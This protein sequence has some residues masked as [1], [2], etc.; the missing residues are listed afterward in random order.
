MD[1][2]A[3]AAVSSRSRLAP[4]A[5]ENDRLD[6]RSSGTLR[7]NDS[8]LQLETAGVPL[9]AQLS[10]PSSRNSSVSSSATVT[11]TQRIASSLEQLS[12]LQ[13]IEPH[14]VPLPD[15]AELSIPQSHAS[16]RNSTAGVGSGYAFNNSLEQ[17]HH[18]H[19]G[20]PSEMPLPASNSS[21]SVNM[22]GYSILASRN[23]AFH[24]PGIVKRDYW[25]KIGPLTHFMP[26]LK[27]VCPPKGRH[28]HAGKITCVDYFSHGDSRVGITIDM[29]NVRSCSG[30][31]PAIRQ[32]KDLRTVKDT[33]VRSRIIL[34]E[35]LCSESIELL[36]T[37]FELDPEI[38]AEHLNRSGYDDEDYSETDAER[39]NTTHLEKDFVS[40]TWCRPLYQ[41]PQLTE[42]LR[43]PRK[44][45]NK[46]LDRPDGMSSVTWRDPIF[47]AAGKRNR[48]ASKHRLRV[49]NNIFRRNWSLSAGT[50]G[51]NGQLRLTERR[52]KMPLSE[53][54]PTLV[55]TAWQERASFCRIREDPDIP[56]GKRSECLTC[57][58]CRPLNAARN[59]AT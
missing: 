21:E 13:A 46:N 45:L 57:R 18:L 42:W 19:P 31:K 56:I 30:R 1:T 11:G 43:A 6:L 4:S 47:T 8:L 28:K 35:D 24:A 39:W 3:H 16:S 51:L 59:S 22:T 36:G 10:L 20:D 34:V 7:G 9:Q 29:S 37:T 38:F 52:S 58:L 17:L 12:Q 33:S 25:Q 40:M 50:A 54:R 48:L 15:D 55:P 2:P 14:N 49:D 27:A 41:N 44:L 26:H 32:L 53:L 23:G 5:V